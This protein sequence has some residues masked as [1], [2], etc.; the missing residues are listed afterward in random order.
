LPR[1]PSLLVSRTDDG[2]IT[3]SEL[4]GGKELRHFGEWHIGGPPRLS[5]ILLGPDGKTLASNG[6][7][8]EKVRLW[9][10]TSG[11]QTAT[12]KADL[13]WQN[14]PIYAM[15]F[16]PDGKILAGTTMFG[17]RMIFWNTSSGELLGIIH[18]PGRTRSIAL[19]P[20]GKTLASAHG[21]GTVKLWEWEKL[22]PKN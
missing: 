4:D 7:S 16:T 10:L 15:A 6:E 5:S 19:S 20:D 18:F 3:V 22:V 2:T 21:D 14:W 13:T 9:D 1:W 12:L 8:N 11:E 17:A